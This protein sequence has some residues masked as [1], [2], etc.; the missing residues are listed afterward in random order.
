MLRHAHEMKFYFKSK[1]IGLKVALL[2]ILCNGY[3]TYHMTERIISMSVTLPEL[4]KK[5]SFV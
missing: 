2:I 1:S 4:Q 5:I 3:L